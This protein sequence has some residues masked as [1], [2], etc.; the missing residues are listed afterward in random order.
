M[1]PAIYKGK[2]RIRKGTKTE[3]CMQTIRFNQNNQETLD[4]Q[5]KQQDNAHRPAE[6]EI[7]HYENGKMPSS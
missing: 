7:E 5:T 3:Q 4:V 1:N 6:N 2:S